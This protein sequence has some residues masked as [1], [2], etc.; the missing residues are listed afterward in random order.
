MEGGWKPS[1]VR[2]SINVAKEFKIESIN[3]FR[4]RK[5]REDRG[6][7]PWSRLVVTKCVDYCRWSVQ[8]SPCGRESLAVCLWLIGCYCQHTDTTLFQ[9]ALGSKGKYLSAEELKK[10]KKNPQYTPKDWSKWGTESE[11]LSCFF[12]CGENSTAS[13]LGVSSWQGHCESSSV[14]HISQ[15]HET[16]GFWEGHPVPPQGCRKPPKQS[17]AWGWKI[18]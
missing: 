6:T 18:L 7:W 4:L 1:C 12:F 17:L 8:S 14:Q 13:E 2:I 11:R 10:K 3:R 5:R 9:E 15:Q 16:A